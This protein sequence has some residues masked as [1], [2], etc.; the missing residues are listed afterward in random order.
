[1]LEANVLPAVLA[2]GVGLGADGT[3]EGLDGDL[4]VI[5]EDMVPEVGRRDELLVAHRAGD[6]GLCSVLALVLGQIGL[7]VKDQVAVRAVPDLVPL[8]LRDVGRLV[9][10]VLPE[11]VV[12]QG[13]LVPEGRPAD[14]AHHARQVTVH[15]L[16]V[17]LEAT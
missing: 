6:V 12:L 1:M 13:V 10:L 17:N 15:T 2:P 7:V 5:T 11:N 16:H 3:G 8:F 9:V 4:E 14:V